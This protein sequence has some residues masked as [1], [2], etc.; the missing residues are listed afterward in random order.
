M[1]SQFA[2]AWLNLRASYINLDA[3]T[4]GR[5]ATPTKQLEISKKDA[6]FTETVIPVHIH[7]IRAP[8]TSWQSSIVFGLSASL[9]VRPLLWSL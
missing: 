4:P 7:V 8:P 5:P 6:R 9:S 2:V 3:A 1:S